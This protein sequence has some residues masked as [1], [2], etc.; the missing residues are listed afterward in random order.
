[1]GV[2][3]H[4]RLVPTQPISRG[5]GPRRRLPADP[6]PLG[7]VVLRRADGSEAD[8]GRGARRH[9]HRRRRRRAW[10]PGGARA[11][12]RGD[13]PGDPAPAHVDL[14][15]GRGLC[16]RHP[17]R[18]WPAVPDDLVTDHVPE[19]EHGG[20]RAA[21]LRDVLDMRSGVDFSEDYLDLDADV[22][23]MEEAM[24]WRPASHPEV[25]QSMYAYLTALGTAREHGGVF[26]YR[27]CETDVL[28][29][30]CERASGTRM[31]D[32]I[33]S[34]SGRP[35]RRAGCRDHL[36][37]R[38]RRDPRRGDVRDGSRPRAVRRDAARRR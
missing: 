34:S 2:L 21:R 4:A 35:R 12:R 25:P 32:L 5:A 10:W 6:R 20:Y 8:R 18:A 9:L 3:A 15:V 19:L 17:G 29:W 7:E 38:R 37:R 24:G 23:V 16:R 31:A 27:S 11:L 30:V 1:M 22:R 14:Q 26:D 36:R 13:R 28:G 33:S